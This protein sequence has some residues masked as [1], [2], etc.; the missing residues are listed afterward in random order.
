VQHIAADR[1]A[2]CIV[3]RELFRLAADQSAHGLDGRFERRHGGGAH[4]LE[5]VRHAVRDLVARALA[6][7]AFAA[8]HDLGDRELLLCAQREQLGGIFEIHNV[9]FSFTVR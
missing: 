7:L 6:Q 9:P 8:A 3:L 5:R 2:L 4:D 1:A